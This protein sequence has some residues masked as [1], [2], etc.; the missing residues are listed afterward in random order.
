MKTTVFSCRNSSINI[1]LDRKLSNFAFAQD[2]VLIEVPG[3]L[4]ILITNLYNGIALFGM[5]F[6]GVQRLKSKA[7]SRWEQLVDVDLFI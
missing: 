5:R 4:R 7:Y 2:V 6:A 3:I 1:C